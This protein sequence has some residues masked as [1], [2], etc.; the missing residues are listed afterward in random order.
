MTTTKRREQHIKIA[1]FFDHHL[2]DE[3]ELLTEI[4]LLLEG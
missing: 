3:C 4:H 1:Y 2:D